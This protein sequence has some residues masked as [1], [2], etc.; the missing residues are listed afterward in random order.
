GFPNGR[1]PGDDVIDTLLY[2]ITNQALVMGDNV[3]N[4]EVPLTSTFPYLGVTHQPFPTGT[5]DDRT[6]N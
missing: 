6:R 2:F 4:N 3:N 5:I 1:R